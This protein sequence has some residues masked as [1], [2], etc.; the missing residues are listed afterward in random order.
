MHGNRRYQH[1]PGVPVASIRSASADAVMGRGGAMRCEG[2]AT[3]RGV[4]GERAR[5]T[6]TSEA[7]LPGWWAGSLAG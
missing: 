4:V 3:G 7:V 6:T 1:P 2:G 5:Q